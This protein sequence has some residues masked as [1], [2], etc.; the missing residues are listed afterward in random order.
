MSDVNGD[1]VP[2]STARYTPFGDWRT[3]PGTNPAIT[4]RG[5][6]GHNS[7]NSGAND[8]GLIYM[9]ARYYVPYLNRFIS[10]DTIVPNP[11]DPQSFNRYAFT[12]NNPLKYTDPTGH[13]AVI[14][15]GGCVDTADCPEIMSE[16]SKAD[17]WYNE[18]GQDEFELIRNPYLQEAPR[19]SGDEYAQWAWDNYVYCALNDCDE[20]I[21][22][23]YSSQMEPYLKKGWEPEGY[24]MEQFHAA[25]LS[26]DLTL[27]P[28]KRIIAFALFYQ[29]GSG[30]SMFNGGAGAL[31]G[32]NQP[33]VY[34]GV[35]NTLVMD[36]FAR[37]V[38]HII[39]PTYK[40]F[41]ADLW[42]SL[43]GESD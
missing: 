17:D 38:I 39:R 12:L 1:L 35:A 37:D 9:N 30:P 16:G 5:Y 33:S 20:E 29:S 10:A 6:T 8:L 26:V 13:Y 25:G 42:S 31:Y 40:E 36:Y 19:K 7:N 43:I 15:E 32:N 41:F 4:D 27:D 24:W 11:Q 21:I 18:G 28:D 22:H 34:T 23:A 3:E 2:D 14:E